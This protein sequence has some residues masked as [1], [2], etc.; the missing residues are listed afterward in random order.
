MFS[1][2]LL[3]SPFLGLLDSTLFALETN[4]GSCCEEG[5]GGGKSGGAGGGGGGGG[6][7]G[8]GNGEAIDSAGGSSG[9]ESIDESIN[10]ADF[11]DSLPVPTV[12]F[13]VEIPL[14]NFFS[15]FFALVLHFVSPSLEVVFDA[16][17]NC[18]M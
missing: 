11:P 10:E 8:A 9:A 5:S 2:V 12:F 6:G 16:E 7:G 14:G 4:F 18:L 13:S 3:F 15:A 1:S 17:L